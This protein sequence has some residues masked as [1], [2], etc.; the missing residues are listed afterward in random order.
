MYTSITFRIDTKLFKTNPTIIDAMLA[1]LHLD[2]TFSGYDSSDKEVV[3]TIYKAIMTLLGKKFPKQ[4]F[5]IERYII[6]TQDY[7]KTDNKV[8]LRQNISSI[9]IT[10]EKILIH[11]ISY[12]YRIHSVDMGEVSIYNVIIKEIQEHITTAFNAL[13]VKIKDGTYQI[14]S[15]HWGLN[16]MNEILKNIKK[17]LPQG[18]NTL[19][20]DNDV[21]TKIKNL[22]NSFNTFRINQLRNSGSHYQLSEEQ[23]SV[24][25]LQ[26]S[27]HNLREFIIQIKNDD[28]YPHLFYFKSLIKDPELPY[29]VKFM[30][31]Y[32]MKAKNLFY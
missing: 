23:Q 22:T 21:L 27:I 10:I 13:Q 28:L 24:E 32:G 7:D 26:L 31:E 19:A 14:D 1:Q 18:N 8:I 3:D 29:Q 30:D 9:G 4:I 17:I 16:D 5:S 2:D 15:T 6:G 20:I 11:I 25:K 12:L